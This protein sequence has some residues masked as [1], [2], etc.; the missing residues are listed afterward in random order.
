M[1]EPG[2]HAQS[3]TGKWGAT[4]GRY[5]VLQRE[6]FWV[7]KVGVW[8]FKEGDNVSVVSRPHNSQVCAIGHPCFLFSLS[9]GR[10]PSIV[11]AGLAVALL[12]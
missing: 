8:L 11:A 9:H 10:F 2:L 12:S 5:G 3:N 7:G 4:E 6:C 1:A